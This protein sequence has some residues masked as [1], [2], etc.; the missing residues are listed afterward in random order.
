[1]IEI[2]VDV[3]DLLDVVN[4]SRLLSNTY[5][6]ILAKNPAGLVQ[7]SM[8]STTNITWDNF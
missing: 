8:H 4:K 3:D 7:I 1:M 2:M 5:V 6:P